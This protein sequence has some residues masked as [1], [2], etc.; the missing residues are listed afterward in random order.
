MD[1]LIML[2]YDGTIVDSLAVFC[3]A[4]VRV[5]SRRGFPHLATCEQATA[6]L[7]SNWFEALASAGIPQDVAD[8]LEEEFAASAW[9][10]DAPSPFGGM[11]GVIERLARQNVVV[12]VTSV[13]K[14]DVEG[15]LARHHVEGVREVLGSDT[16][17]SKVRKIEQA[18]A[19]HGRELEAW[20]VGDT[21]GDIAEARQAGVR[22]IA[23]TWGWGDRERLLAAQPDIV[24]E[25]PEDLLALE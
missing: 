23:V 5:F 25:T 10:D 22:S 8:E 7:E 6:L 20:Y 2:D 13:R 15:V 12:V 19:H 16:E 14:P 24:A 18:R 9:S 21:V 1:R 17:P 4:C 3:D 11:P